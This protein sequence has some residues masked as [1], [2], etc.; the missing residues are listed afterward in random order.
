[1]SNGKASNIHKLEDELRSS[2]CRQQPL[3]I[4]HHEH[5]MQNPATKERSDAMGMNTHVRTGSSRTIKER[6]VRPAEALHCSDEAAVEPD[7]P[8]QPRHLGPVVPPRR[9]A[10]VP[11][12]AGATAAHCPP[13]RR[14]TL[15]QPLLSFVGL[16]ALLCYLHSGTAPPR[17]A[18]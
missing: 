4:N 11:P 13:L 5:A 8:P 7:R 3:S 2:F 1:M 14:Q 17:P 6:T 9:R 12:S 15:L 10:P 16:P 18:S